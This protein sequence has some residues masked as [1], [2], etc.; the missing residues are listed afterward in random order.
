MM[1]IRETIRAIRQS[2]WSFTDIRQAVAT[3]ELDE[4]LDATQPMPALKQQRIAVKN[5]AGDI[6]WIDLDG[7]EPDFGTD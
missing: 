1:S 7:T 6:E 4:E 5:R 3:V 2:G